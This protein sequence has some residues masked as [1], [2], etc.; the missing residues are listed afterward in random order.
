MRTGCSVSYMESIQHA[1]V[2]KKSKIINYQ[3]FITTQINGRE[4][5]LFRS[6]LHPF[7]TRIYIPRGSTTDEIRKNTTKSTPSP[8]S[9]QLIAVWHL[10]FV[11]ESF[12]VSVI[13]SRKVAKGGMI[14]GS[15]FWTVNGCV[16]MQE[17]G[18]A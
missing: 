3:T 13:K 5:L 2:Q 9:N 16:M 11:A 18:A 17:C 7:T 10:L 14:W 8:S 4:F 12:R 6:W 1:D 15:V